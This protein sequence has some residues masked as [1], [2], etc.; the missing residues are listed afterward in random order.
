MKLIPLSQGK[1]TQVD[2]ED[3]EYISQFK[4]CYGGYPYRTIKL[5]G[6]WTTITMHREIMKPDKDLQVDHIDGNGLNNQK[7]NLRICTYQQNTMNRRKNNGDHR[8]KGVY[9][10]SRHTNNLWQMVIRVTKN[11]ERIKYTKSFSTEREAV[12]AYNQKA[13]ELFGEFARLNIIDE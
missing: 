3:F 5:N 13:I 6:K 2:D 4:W 7:S 8:Y 1:F 9:F 11:G 10:N 12:L